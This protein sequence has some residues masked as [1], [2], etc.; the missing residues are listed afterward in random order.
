METLNGNN[1]DKQPSKLDIAEKNSLFCNSFGIII[2]ISF[3]LVEE[4]STWMCPLGHK[5]GAQLTLSAGSREYRA[6]GNNLV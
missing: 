5:N 1:Q 6:A 4:S 2:V 3:R